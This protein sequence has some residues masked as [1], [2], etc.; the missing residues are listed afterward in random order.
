MM[1]AIFLASFVA[2]QVKVK[3]FYYFPQEFIVY[4]LKSLNSE[5]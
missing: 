1:M 3:C 5:P 2:A 4:N